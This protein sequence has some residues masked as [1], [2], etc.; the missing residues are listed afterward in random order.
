MEEAPHAY[1]AVEPVVE[2]IE[3]AGIARKVAR[4]H[5]LCTAKG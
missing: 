2:S 5:S 1:E 4:L 3:A